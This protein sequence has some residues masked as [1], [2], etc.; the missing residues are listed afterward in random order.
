[1]GSADIT[2]PDAVAQPEL[3]PFTLNIT[4]LI[5]S[6]ACLEGTGSRI[7]SC[8][9]RTS[10]STPRGPLGTERRLASSTSTSPDPGGRLS[11]LGPGEIKLNH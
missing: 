10:S 1:M 8:A 9:Q 3:G 4:S 6:K 11:A 2:S 5:S 7:C